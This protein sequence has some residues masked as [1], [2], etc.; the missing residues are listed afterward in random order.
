M[1]NGKFGDFSDVISS[2]FLSETRESKSGLTTSTVLL[3]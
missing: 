3:G 2:S 1:L